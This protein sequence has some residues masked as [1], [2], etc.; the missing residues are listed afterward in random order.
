CRTPSEPNWITG[1]RAGY[2]TSSSWYIL[3]EIVLR[4]NGRPFAEYAR[5]NVLSRCGMLNSSLALPLDEFRRIE[6]RLA[7][8]YHTEKKALAP[9]RKWNSAADAAVCRPGRS[10]RGPI[11]ELGL[12]YELLLQARKGAQPAATA[13]GLQPATVLQLTRSWRIGMF[14]E[15]F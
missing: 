13:L 5:A 10:G 9:H 8:T 7:F 2:H 3:A 6:D 4:L 12:F 14:D 11:R 1:E 15:T